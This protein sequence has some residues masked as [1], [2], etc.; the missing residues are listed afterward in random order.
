MIKV[1]G[2]EGVGQRLHPA[3]LCSSL[4]RDLVPTILAWT[5]GG[6]GRPQ[7]TLAPVVMFA[8]ADVIGTQPLPSV[9]VA[10]QSR[11]G[12]S[13][14]AGGFILGQAEPS[15]TPVG[16]G[17]TSISERAM[18]RAWLALTLLPDDLLKTMCLPNKPSNGGVAKR[19]LLLHLINQNSISGWIKKCLDR[20]TT[21]IGHPLS[22]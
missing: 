10:L 5:T 4:A 11:S 6:T 22:R 18:A 8:E 15:A 7:H 9:H 3:I 12:V 19:R 16:A 17:T 2:V 13:R 20:Q 14:V 21:G 1:Q